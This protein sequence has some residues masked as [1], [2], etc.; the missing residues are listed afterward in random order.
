MKNNKVPIIIYLSVWCVTVAIFWLFVNN[1]LVILFGVIVFRVLLPIT[2][3]VVSVLIGANDHWGKYKWI[4]PVILG[5][6]Y[7]LCG[8][9]TFSVANTIASGNINMP[10]VKLAFPAAIISVVG[11]AIGVGIDCFKKRKDRFHKQ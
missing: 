7:I 1:P 6:M 4:A 11:L 5:I 8:Y 10:E 9:A 3:F 2:T